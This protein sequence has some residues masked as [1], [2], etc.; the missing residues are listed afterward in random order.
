MVGEEAFG[1]H[2]GNRFRTPTDLSSELNAVVAGEGAFRNVHAHHPIVQHRSLD[3]AGFSRYRFAGM[4]GS[5]QLGVVHHGQVTRPKTVDPAQMRAAVLATVGW[6]ADDT[7]PQPDRATL[8]AAVRQSARTVAQLA[9]GASV[10]VRV[11][12]FVA[13]QCIP[14]PRH[15]RGTPPNVVEMSPRVWLE[16]VTGMVSFD[17]AVASGDV[18]ASG[19]RAAEVAQ[20]LPLI[21]VPR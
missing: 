17:A 10:E 8:A 5:T 9:P 15:T 20:L 19:S 1:K 18:A 3:A 11:P 6:L 7:E 13:V 12:P 14:G 16:L 2:A 4:C 21:R